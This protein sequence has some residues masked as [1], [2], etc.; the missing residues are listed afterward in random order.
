MIPTGD[1]PFLPYTGTNAA[2]KDASTQTETIH[3]DLTYCPDVSRDDI[4][5]LDLLHVML[6]ALAIHTNL[7]ASDFPEW[8]FVTAVASADAVVF[9]KCTLRPFGRALLEPARAITPTAGNYTLSEIDI[10]EVPETLA[11]MLVS[12]IEGQDDELITAHSAAVKMQCAGDMHRSSNMT[13]DLQYTPSVLSSKEAHVLLHQLGHR[14]VSLLNAPKTSSLLDHCE[15]SDLDMAIL[16][17]LSKTGPCRELPMLIQDCVKV[18][19]LRIPDALAVEAWDGCLSY[20]QLSEAT[21][22]LASHFSSC[23][24]RGTVGIICG[25][26][27]W[28]PV[29]ILASL[30]SG[31]AF[32][33]LDHKIPQARLQ[34][35]VRECAA[36]AI[37]A[38]RSFTQIAVNLSN[39]VISVNHAGEGIVVGSALRSVPLPKPVMARKPHEQAFVVFTSGTSSIPKGISISHTAWCTN[40]IH[41]SKAYGHTEHSRTLHQSSHSFIV[42][43]IE[44]LATLMLGGTVCVPEDGERENDLNGAIRRLQPNYLIISPSAGAVLSPSAK[45]PI[46][47]VLLVGEVA[48]TA[49]IERLLAV[50]TTVFIGYGASEMCGQISAY[51]VATAALDQVAI[52]PMS[53]GRLWIVHPSCSN[54][55]TP[56]LAVGELV[57]ESHSVAT[58]YISGASEPSPF[59][60]RPAWAVPPV[61]DGGEECRWYRT[62]D[63][64]RYTAAGRLEVVGRK[65]YQI[66]LRGQKVS[67]TEVEH[68]V[69]NECS[70]ELESVV[71]TGKENDQGGGD[72]KLIIYV[73]LRQSFRAKILQQPL[74][75]VLSA[76]SGVATAQHLKRWLTRVCHERLAHVLPFWMI[77]TEVVVLETL[78][79][80]HTGKP[81]RRRIRAMAREHG[82][83]LLDLESRLAWPKIADKSPLELVGIWTEAFNTIRADLPLDTKL[84][85]LGID[86]ISAM[87]LVNAARK[88]GVYLT[89]QKV[90]G[91]CT[92]GDLA[93]ALQGAQHSA[94]SVK[95][96]SQAYPAPDARHCAKLPV[97]DFQ[98]FA[99][100]MSSSRHKALVY[101]FQISFLGTVE[102][103]R[104]K[105]A[106]VSLIE[107]TDSLR[108]KIEGSSKEGWYQSVFPI[109]DASTLVTEAT[110]AGEA[111]N[112]L[113]PVAAPAVFTIVR[114]EINTLNVQELLIRLHHCVFDAYSMNLIL[115]LLASIYEHGINPHTLRPQYIPYLRNHLL[116]RECS[117]L[118]YWRKL[119]KGSS[120]T[121][122]RRSVAQLCDN[123][124]S[125]VDIEVRKVVAIPVTSITP[126]GVTLATLCKAA[127]ALVLTQLSEIPDVMFL[128]IV[129]GRLDSVPE[130]TSIIGCCA[131]EIPVRVQVDY[132]NDLDTRALLKQVQ[133]Q[134]FESIAHAHIGTRAV[135]TSCTDWPRKNE[136]YRHSTFLQFQNVDEMR[137]FQ[138]GS[139][140][141]C[142]VRSQTNESGIYDF[143]LF[144]RPYHNTLEISLKAS[145]EYSLAEVNSVIDL[146]S[147]LLFGLLEER[148]LSVQDVARAAGALKPRVA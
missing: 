1:L 116:R 82:S 102:V 36:T 75:G 108:T 62:G 67:P 32:V 97:T 47:A 14:I 73:T 52:G 2:K 139:D 49:L 88:R 143:V 23:G 131:T 44:I 133:T 5:S 55:L 91:H 15:P 96:L 86:S 8:S 136:M 9:H 13:L 59:I 21:H 147:E 94:D 98:R 92:M 115:K 10:S 123:E 120:P 106:I 24:L 141:Y 109:D 60:Q 114:S 33:L 25:K 35:M 129:S 28:T 148:F 64:V 17:E 145:S 37:I 66:K 95:Y 110:S 63:L 42:A 43:H 107:A 74:A 46:K 27:M 53:T 69:M 65:D 105:A 89:V 72:T 135:S 111:S 31:C 112:T 100:D 85:D 80:T 127:W 50:G 61:V 68:H 132:A 137:S 6:Q 122:L 39:R 146:F 20:A 119:L 4:S 19:G 134:H 126:A 81:D 56:Y 54:I 76:D 7:V 117:S 18:A 142:H 104:L 12:R 128:T 71:A 103:S 130:S 118:E 70:T 11:F 78:P 84:I 93:S 45:W 38:T 26:S 22:K 113:S 79:R 51:R 124:G 41:G 121:L 90:L 101:N 125:T 144:I 87:L 57:V 99:L 34:V 140:A 40:Y 77:P 48:T 83:E 138:M 58:C 16:R 29:I 30:R 3:Q